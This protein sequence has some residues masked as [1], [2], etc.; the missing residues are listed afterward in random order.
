LHRAFF[1]HE[2]SCHKRL[3]TAEARRE[4]ARLESL[5]EFWSRRSEELE[6]P[7][8]AKASKQ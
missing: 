4:H 1:I 8:S 5:Y 7:P 2:M 3:E 6:E